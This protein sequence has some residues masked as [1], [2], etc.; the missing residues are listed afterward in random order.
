MKFGIV[1]KLLFVPM[2][3]SLLSLKGSIR[4]VR[5]FSQNPS[6]R[7]VI[8]SVPSVLS[9]SGKLRFQSNLDASVEDD[10]DTALSSFLEGSG[11]KASKL[12]DVIPKKELVAGYQAVDLD[13]LLEETEV[14]FPLV[15][16]SLIL[17]SVF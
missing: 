6:T 4:L 8:T 5:A 14:R 9:Q 2:L 12:N 11:K 1:S 7:R 17:F 10:L 16:F 13:D 3:L 15:L